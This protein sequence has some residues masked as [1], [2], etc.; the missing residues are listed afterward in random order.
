MREAVV[1][2]VGMTPMGRFEETSLK[3]LAASAIDEAMKDAGVTFDDIQAV[4]FGNVGAGIMHGQNSIRGET[5]THHMGAGVMAVNNV[6]NA[7]ATGANAMHLGWSSVAGGQYDTVLVVG[8]EKL[9]SQDKAKSFEV[10]MGGMDVDFRDYGEGAG[11]TRSPFIDRYAKVA[12]FLIRERGVSVENFAQVAAKAHANGALNPLAQRRTPRTV[13]EI[14]AAR[15]VLGPLT[16]LMCSP[17]GDGAAAA[18]ITRGDLDRRNGDVQ[19][20]ASQLRSLPA[21]ASGPSDSHEFSAQAAWEQSGLGPEDM[22]FA[23]LH[24]A[25]APGEIVSWV[26]SGLCPAGDEVKWAETGHTTLGGQMPVNPSG[27][28]VARGHPIGATGM[29]QVYEAVTQLR[30]G[31]GQRQI[32]DARRA[33]VQCGGGLIKGTTA[34]SAAHIL[35]I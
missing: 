13:E 28:L 20:L 25:T 1:R 14:L 11:V 5:V 24:D 10:F 30:G 6:E 17:V 33:F 2:G 34:V 29:A 21:D 26:E 18:V 35:G 15:H 7:C 4:F 23:E 8:A 3:E 12:D 19:I 31:A 22:D 16:V 9:Y 32:A 27:G